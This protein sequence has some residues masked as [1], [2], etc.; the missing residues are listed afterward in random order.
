[1]TRRNWWLG[2]ALIA[3]LILIARYGWRAVLGGASTAIEYGL[4]GFTVLLIV[5][6][7]MAGFA[8]SGGFKRP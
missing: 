1:M 8:E 4:V 5:V 6:A 2:V 3:A 7:V